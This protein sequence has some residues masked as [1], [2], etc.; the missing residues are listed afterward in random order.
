LFDGCNYRLLIAPR[1]FGCA[2][3]HRALVPLAGDDNEVVGIGN[4]CS[5]R[6]CLRMVIDG[7]EIIAREAARAPSPLPRNSSHLWQLSA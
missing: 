3:A 4:L 5:K 1:I 6:N 7:K 2:K